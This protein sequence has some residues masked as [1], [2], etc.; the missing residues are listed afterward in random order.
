LFCFVNEGV[1]H[2]VRSPSSRVP[3]PEAMPEG[4]E[5]VEAVVG[6][7]LPRQDLHRRVED[8]RLEGHRR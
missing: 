7:H 5:D 4:G 6:L 8:H 1:F 2:A 3:N